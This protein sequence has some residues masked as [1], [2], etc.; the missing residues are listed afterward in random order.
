MT[1][2]SCRQQRPREGEAPAEPA[3]C[4]DVVSPDIAR[5]SFNRVPDGPRVRAII[6]GASKQADARSD[7]PRLNN[8]S[9]MRLIKRRNPAAPQT[10]H[11]SV[12][13]Q[14]GTT[15]NHANDTNPLQA[16]AP[17]GGRSSC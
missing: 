15:T 2:I 7:A 14:V 8:Q 1:H 12:P 9:C 3:S 5:A 11:S 13:V 10:E 6:D 4:S 16:A 17:P